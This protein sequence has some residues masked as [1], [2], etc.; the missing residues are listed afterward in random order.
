MTIEYEIEPIPGLPGDL[1]P[2]ERILWQG[3]PDWKRLARTAFHAR[4]VGVYF[5][6]LALIGVGL[7]IP[8]IGEGFG[9]FAGSLVT[10][11]VGIVGV[12]LLHGL[13]WLSARSTIYT[14]TNKRVVFRIGIALPKCINLPLSM[15]GSA[16]LRSYPDGTGDVPLALTGNQRLGYAQL[17]PHA[18]AWHVNVAQPMMRAVPGAAD[19]ANLLE[20]ATRASLDERSV[21]PQLFAV[22]A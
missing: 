16:D 5:A 3:K 15:I 14:I 10:I 2:G 21:E 9:A 18:R 8:N 22:A 6:V 11:G 20:R 4:Q 12:A 17:W 13:A 19:V 1:P 7:A